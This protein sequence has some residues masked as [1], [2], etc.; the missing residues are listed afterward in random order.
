MA[1]FPPTPRRGCAPQ[2]VAAG[3]HPITHTQERQ[4]DE[5]TTQGARCSV[6]ALATVAALAG[7]SRERRAADGKT[8]TPRRHVPARSRRRSLR[9]VRRA[10]GAVREAQPRHRRHR[11]RVRVD[12]PDLRRAARRRKPARRL[13]GAVH[14]RQDAARERPAHGRDRGDGR[15]SATPTSSTRSSSTRSRTPT[16]TSSASRARRTPWAC[17]TTATCSSGRAR[18]RQP[19]D[20]VGRGPRGREGD[21]R[22]DRQGRLRAD[23]A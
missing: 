12:R 5:V 9:G 11:C 23:D 3:D 10:G 22:R 17:T 4:D 16:A 20:H 8:E 21:L 13:H 1:S 18:P 6:A 7:C 19:A 15:R 14:R 2:H